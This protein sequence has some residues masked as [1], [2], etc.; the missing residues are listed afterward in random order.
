MLPGAGYL[1]KGWGKAREP[2]HMPFANLPRP[3]VVLG[4]SGWLP[5][6]ICLWLVLAGG[7]LG[8]SALAAGCFYAA[9]I[10][11]FLGGMWWMT[12]LLRGAR[13]AEI[14]VAAVLPSLI[15]LGALLP[16]TVGWNWPGPALAVL[17]ALLLASPLVDK[18]LSRMVELPA[19]WLA[20]RMVMAGGLGTLTLALAWAEQGLA[21]R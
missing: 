18:W 10:L 21:G 6:A 13:H 5:Q 16:W 20:L 17:G 4:L 11:S 3:V 14:Y 1:G 7:P 19:G 9:L 8:W 2:H 12:A 15:G